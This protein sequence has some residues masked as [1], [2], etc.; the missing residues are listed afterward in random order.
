MSV[1]H[2]S[3]DLL[4]TWLGRTTKRRNVLSTGTF[5]ICILHLQGLAF[6]FSQPSFLSAV[7]LLAGIFRLAWERVCLHC[8]DVPSQMPKDALRRDWVLIT[9]L[10]YPAF[11]KTT[12]LCVFGFLFFIFKMGLVQINNFPRM[13][14]LTGGYKE[15]RNAL[16]MLSQIMKLHLCKNAIVGINESEHYIYSVIRL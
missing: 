5:F 6:V 16:S 12:Y 9:P 15:L 8:S 1:H 11:S 2:W 10:S 4:K 7:E 13:C 3:F 14:E